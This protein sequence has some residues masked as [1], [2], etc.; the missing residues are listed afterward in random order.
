MFG[1]VW[2]ELRQAQEA[3]RDGRLEEALR[4]LNE[5]AARNQRGSGALLVQLAR[6]YVERGERLL[7]RDDVESAWNDLLQAEQ[8][9]TAERSPERLRDALTRLGLAEVRGVLLAGDP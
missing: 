1:F 7:R 9:Q 3:L 6:A 4:L 2:L 5:P 8:L